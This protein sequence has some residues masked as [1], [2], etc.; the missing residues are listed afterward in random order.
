M[1][2]RRW[3]RVLLRIRGDQ[4]NECKIWGIMGLKLRSLEESA[5]AC[6]GDLCSWT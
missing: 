1:R 4:M 3:R 6:K 2:L 5:R